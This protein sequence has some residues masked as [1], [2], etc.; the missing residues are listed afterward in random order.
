MNLPSG[1]LAKG[2][3]QRV[4]GR[5]SGSDRQREVGGDREHRDAPADREPAPH[6]RR[7]PA[8][9]V[10]GGE[11]QDEMPARG[12]DPDAGRERRA[13]GEPGSD[14]DAATAANEAI[15]R[16]FAAVIARNRA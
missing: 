6:A 3:T 12:G 7:Y 13:R 5:L 14:S 11:R 16:G 10:A 15:V 8:P 4:A 2:V 1:D 9:G